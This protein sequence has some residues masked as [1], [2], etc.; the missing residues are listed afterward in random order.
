[1]IT[2]RNDTP[3]K[4]NFSF[5]LNAISK[6]T[7]SLLRGD[8]TSLWEGEVSSRHSEEADLRDIVLAPGDTRFIFQSNLPA[9]G[10]DNDT[11]LLDLIM[12]NLVIEVAP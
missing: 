9:S 12:K 7:A 2:N 3:I 11:R 6:R 5:S 1:V 10:A 8:G 4:G